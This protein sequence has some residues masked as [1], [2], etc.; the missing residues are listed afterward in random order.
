MT[1]CFQ[2]NKSQ[3]ICIL[4]WIHTNHFISLRFYFCVCIYSTIHNL[5]VGTLLWRYRNTF[6]SST[7]FFAW[8]DIS[9]WGAFIWNMMCGRWQRGVELMFCCHQE[10]GVTGVPFVNF[11]VSKNL[12]LAKVPLRWFE[13]HLYLTG[14]TAAELRWHL[15]NL[16]VIFNS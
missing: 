10:V 1:F 13:S 4:L 7:C 3:G 12:Y 2:C 9:S 11:S 16:N 14:P 15:T 8:L 6:T 5:N